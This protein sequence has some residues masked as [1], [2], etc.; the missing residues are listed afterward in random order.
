MEDY[1]SHA[2][3]LD[4]HHHHHP[5]GKGKPCN[6]TRETG[7]DTHPRETGRGADGRQGTQAAGQASQGEGLLQKRVGP[8]RS[9]GGQDRCLCVW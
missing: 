4:H 3:K 9:Q 6:V 7:S 2:K 5:V 1:L 8:H